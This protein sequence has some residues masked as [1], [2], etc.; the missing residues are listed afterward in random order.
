MATDGSPC[1]VAIYVKVT[2]IEGDPLW[3]HIA[4]GQAFCSNVLQRDFRYQIQSDGYDTCHLPPNF[5]STHDVYAYF[6]F[7][8]GVTGRLPRENLSHFVYF[9]SRVEG[10]WSF[11]PRPTAIDKAK[12]RAQ[13]YPW[14]GTVEQEMFA[15]LKGSPAASPSY[16]QGSID[17]D[18]R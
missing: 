17:Q 4:L 3:R 11:I 18:N 16:T 15:E 5:D 2:D 12:Q 6:L 13:K 7:D 10:K 1:R 8:I 9:A 14:G